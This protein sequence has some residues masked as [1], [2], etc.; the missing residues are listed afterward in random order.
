MGFS[1]L[2]V[3]RSLLFVSKLQSVH[4][5]RSASVGI[6]CISRQMKPGASVFALRLRGLHAVRAFGARNLRIVGVDSVRQFF[7]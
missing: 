3:K 1:P 5:N 6:G 7:D 2:W 4:L